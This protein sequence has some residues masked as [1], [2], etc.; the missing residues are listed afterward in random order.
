MH[1]SKLKTTLTHEHKNTDSPYGRE[2]TVSVK[3]R[4]QLIQRLTI[5]HKELPRFSDYIR[6]NYLQMCLH[7]HC[8][9]KIQS[10][11][12]GGGHFHAFPITSTDHGQK[13]PV[14]GIFVGNHKKIF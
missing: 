7:F 5:K 12:R 3:C 6:C 9:L 4:K 14:R 8:S 13:L 10:Q 1:I 11:R 2:Y